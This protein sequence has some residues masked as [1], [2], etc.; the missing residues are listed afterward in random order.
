MVRRAVRE[1]RNADGRGTAVAISFGRPLHIRASSS[2]TARTERRKPLPSSAP[3]SASLPNPWTLTRRSD[4]CSIDASGII[5][6]LAHFPAGRPNGRKHHLHH[7]DLWRD[8]RRLHRVAVLASARVL[9]SEFRRAKNNRAQ[10]SGGD[11]ALIRPST[12]GFG[13]IWP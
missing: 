10:P 3:L 13:G 4:Q 6:I 8:R 9:I 7:P 2:A 12:G 1:A 5:I 11:H